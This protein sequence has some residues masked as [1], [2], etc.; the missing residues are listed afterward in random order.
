MLWELA[1]GI[2]SLSGVRRELAEGIVGLSGVR[3]KLAEGI[4]SLLGVG[5][6][7]AEGIVGLLGVRRKLA[8]GIG[9]LLGVRRELAEGDRELARMESGVRR[10]KTKTRRKIIGGYRKACREQ[11]DREYFG[12]AHATTV[13][14]HLGADMEHMPIAGLEE[15]R[16]IQR[17]TCVRLYV[18][19]NRSG[20]RRMT[21]NW[22]DWPAPLPAYGL[23]INC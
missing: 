17:T 3:R 12:T 7:L 5:Q 18:D 15:A 23:A 21:G 2:E 14:N 13:G 8:E 22:T 10:K 19:Q 16:W 6:E 4:G 11:D 20:R 9:S 1:E